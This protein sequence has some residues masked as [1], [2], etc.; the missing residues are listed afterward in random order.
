VLIRIRVIAV[1]TAI[2]MVAADRCDAQMAGDQV[3][4]SNFPLVLAANMAVGA[5]TAAIGR[6]IAK[7]NPLKAAVTGAIAGSV[8]FAGKWMVAKNDDRSNLLGRSIAAVGS[9]AVRD[10]AAGNPYLAN[11]VLPYGVVRVHV[12]RLTQKPVSVRLDLA[13]SIATLVNASSSSEQLQ[14]KKS[15][16]SGV[17]FFLIDRNKR[18]GSLEG[19][20]QAGVVTYR[21]ETPF[22][23]QAEETTRKMLG[24]ELA[25]VVQSDFLFIAYASPVE[26]WLFPLLP[27]GRTIHRFVDIGLHVPMLSAANAIVPY[28]DR[29]WEREAVTLA[30]Q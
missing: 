25:H 20:H 3:P 7:K 29:P 10:A 9:S 24:H 8:V 18:G 28:T 26:D 2:A 4:G 22:V 16:I 11:V 15:I 30:R 5:G 23:V 27:G 1:I 21:T 6:I 12:T 17:P 14:L 19:I 13:A